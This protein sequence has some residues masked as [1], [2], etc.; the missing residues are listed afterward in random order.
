MEEELMSGRRILILPA[1]VLGVSLALGWWWRSEGWQGPP[2][3]LWRQPVASVNRIEIKGG[4][5]TWV[6][7]RQ[8]DAWVQVQPF[9]QLADVTA[10]RQLLAAAA[11]AVP[12]YRQP[13]EQVPEAARLRA[14]EATLTIRGA[15]R[16]ATLRIGAGHPAGL[17][18]VAEE[19]SGQAGPCDAELRRRVLAA[20][21]GALLDDHLFEL[22]GADSDRVL[23]RVGGD[24]PA[25]LELERSPAG[26]RM[27][28]PWSSRADAAVVS[29]FLQGLTKL[30]AQGV[31]QR[32]MG[33]GTLHGLKDPAATLTV[34]TLDPSKGSP[35]EETVRLGADAGQGARFARIGDRPA[36]VQLDVQTVSGLVPPAA[37]FV[38][39]R[40]CGLQPSQV[41]AVKIMDAEG[42]A[43][44]VL[45]RTPEGWTLQRPDTA[46]PVDDRNLVELLRSLCET[47]AAGISADPARP[48]WLVGVV[49]LEA[50]AGQTR[51]VQVWRLPDG[52]W[53]MT[54][55][56]GPV[57]VH[58]A[59]LP[60]PL[61]A[62]DHPPK[63]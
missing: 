60:M 57:R 42:S 33:D 53:A 47:R 5:T 39:P 26:W 19:G 28:Q 32:D 38:D 49:E 63:R 52:R 40:A 4:E 29:G 50:D 23:L 31:V 37:A 51:R 43:R 17:A 44:C 35:R 34:R 10:V 24:P 55:G 7:E 18:W 36:V 2:R 27:L 58:P 62:T 3:P 25:V 41:R 61:A 13:L 15:D 54:D 16:M 9:H 8:G 6:Y 22:A 46:V 11:D 48:E 56:D 30:R 12:V 21:E 59:S 20:I 1:A 45:A 14:P